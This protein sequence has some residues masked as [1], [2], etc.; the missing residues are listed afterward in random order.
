MSTTWDLLV[1]SCHSVKHCTLAAWAFQSQQSGALTR[2]LR[3]CQVQH[4]QKECA[5]G[6]VHCKKDE[7]LSSLLE[8][9]SWCCI[10]SAIHHKWDV[11]KE[12]HT[13]ICDVTSNNRVISS[14]DLYYC[15]LPKCEALRTCRPSFLIT[16]QEIYFLVFRM[17]NTWKWPKMNC[18]LRGFESCD[19]SI[20][21]WIWMLSFLLEQIWIGIIFFWTLSQLSVLFSDYRLPQD[22]NL[23]MD[24]S[25][26]HVRSHLLQA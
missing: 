24:C 7:T 25:H 11:H 20:Y 2:I 10:E 5:I 22:C 9:L 12:Q 4:S 16:T 19:I 21:R 23:T 1:A 17:P 26:Q 3:W 8:P 6:A 18:R 13:K 14:G 15:L